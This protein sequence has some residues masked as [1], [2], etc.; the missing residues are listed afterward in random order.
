M[1]AWDPDLVVAYS[2][3]TRREIL[4]NP[5]LSGLGAVERGRV[6]ACPQ[7]IYLWGVRSGEGAMMALWLGK[8]LYPELFA[9][10]DVEAMVRDFFERF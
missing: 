1:L 5:A 9:G 8:E 3:E 6:L 7:G 4:A 2:P 10:V